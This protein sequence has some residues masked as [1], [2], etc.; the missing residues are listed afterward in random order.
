M[1]RGQRKLVLLA[2]GGAAALLA[3]LAIAGGSL[4]WVRIFYSTWD[5]RPNAILL[6]GSV[7]YVAGHMHLE[8]TPPA[9]RGFVQIL[10]RDTGAEAGFQSFKCKDVPLNYQWT[11][12]EGVAASGTTVYAVGHS[13]CGAG[14]KVCVA[15]AGNE[16]C[17]HSSLDGDAFLFAFDARNPT[18]LNPIWGESQ[19]SD[20]EDKAEGVAAYGSNLYVAGHYKGSHLK[21]RG[22]TVTALQNQGAFDV[23]LIRYSSSGSYYGAVG[24]GGSGDDGQPSVAVDS[25]GNVYLTGYMRSSPAYVYTY[26]GGNRT[27]LATLNKVGSGADVFVV[28]FGPALNLLWAKVLGGPDDDKGVAVAATGSDVYL[29]GFFSQYLTLPGCCTLWGHGGKDGFGV[30]LRS[31]DGAPQGG[32]ALGGS[33][34]DEAADLKIIPSTGRIAITGFFSGS[35]TVGPYTLTSRGGRDAYLVEVDRY[36]NVFS[37]ASAGGSATDEGTALGTFS[38]VLIGGVTFQSKPI[39]VGSTSY[40]KGSSGSD[41]D[42]LYYRLNMF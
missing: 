38:N 39:W 2:F 6:T 11:H 3:G 28:K 4:A 13:R 40:P 18:Q 25:A 7:A 24:V 37:A 31:S 23:Y 10:N 16:K 30:L 33:G 36:G 17:Q 29:A 19:Q 27:V 15:L 1:K 32:I 20:G 8:A 42:L 35:M 21:V 34:T 9:S 5:D 41:F 14:G 26:S 12:V 22:K